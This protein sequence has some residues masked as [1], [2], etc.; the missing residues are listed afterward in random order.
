MS[1]IETASVLTIE[2]LKSEC[3]H[4][5]HRDFILR[6]LWSKKYPANLEGFSIE[7]ASLIC[8]CGHYINC[9]SNGLG[10]GISFCEEEDGFCGC[11]YPEV[12]LGE[13]IR[14]LYF[15]KGNGRIRVDKFNSAQNFEKFWFLAT[16]GLPVFIEMEALPFRERVVLA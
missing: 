3:N 8:I 6:K 2:C 1:Q 9:H 12:D 13:N 16:H 5:N 7:N 14:E 4:D 15:Y 10:G 11:M